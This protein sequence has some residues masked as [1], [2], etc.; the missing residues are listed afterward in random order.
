M[1]TSN[2]SLIAGR[3]MYRAILYTRLQFSCGRGNTQ[4]DSVVKTSKH[5]YLV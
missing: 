2:W 4:D 5:F 1:E 3:T